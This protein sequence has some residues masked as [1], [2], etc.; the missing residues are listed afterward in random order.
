MNKCWQRAVLVAVGCA[1]GPVGALGQA[2]NRADGPQWFNARAL[3]LEGKGW[4]DTKQ[5]YD[6]LPARA[7]GD[8]RA[9]TR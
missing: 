5:F 3:T 6:R 8:V 7:E 1:L 4:T 9:A 2:T